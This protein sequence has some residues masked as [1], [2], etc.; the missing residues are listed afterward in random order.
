MRKA[1]ESGPREPLARLVRDLADWGGVLRQSGLRRRSE[2]PDDPDQGVHAS[3]EME[4]FRA[5]AKAIIVWLELCGRDAD[6]A[7]VDD[8]M[9]A[10]REAA[11]R[12]DMRG[13]ES[14]LDEHADEHLSPLELL[15]KVAEETASR[16]EDADIPSD[17]WQGFGDA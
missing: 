14:V 8:A 12:F 13:L 15:I 4:Q 17:V 7:E 10:L 2:G 1:T 6:A 11:R 9:A 5:P 3:E 16:L